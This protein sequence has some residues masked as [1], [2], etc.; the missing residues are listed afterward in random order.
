MTITT[1]R[2]IYCNECDK[3]VGEIRDATLMK[4]IKYLCPSCCSSNLKEDN[5]SSSMPKSDFNSIFNDIF[6]NKYKK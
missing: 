1:I 3:Y 6:K 4:G 5:Y 2:K